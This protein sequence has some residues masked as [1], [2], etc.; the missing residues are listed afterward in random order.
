MQKKKHTQ[1]T[2]GKKQKNILDITL[3]RDTEKNR[4]VLEMTCAEDFEDM[5]AEQNGSI[6]SS[7][8]WENKDGEYHEFYKKTSVHRNKEYRE[9]VSRN[10]NDYGARIQNNG[11]VNIAFLRTKGLQ[12]GK[13][14]LLPNTVSAETAK[15]LVQELE[16]TAGRLY[17]QFCKPFILESSLTR[18]R[19]M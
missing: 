14:F 16:E 13:Q 18:K 3:L 8:S 7:S 17:K 1:A 10:Y 19:V 4:L 2:D 6:S 5:M 15:D 11:S 12:D 9:T